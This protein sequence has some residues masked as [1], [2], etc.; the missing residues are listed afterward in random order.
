MPGD[1]IGKEITDSV[2]EV[3][4]HANA[5]IEWDEFSISGQSSRDELEFQKA[6]RSLQKNKV[7]LKGAFVFALL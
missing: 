5:P 1:G 3:F 2:K 6:V 7:G 4:E